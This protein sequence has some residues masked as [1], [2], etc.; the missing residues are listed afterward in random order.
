MCGIRPEERVGG[1][2]MCVKLS[3]SEMDE[4]MSQKRLRWF[5]HVARSI[6]WINQCHEIE[7]EGP[8]R[9]GR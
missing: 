3:I 9:R 1:A 7:V 4:K 5:G 8:S 6:D 2:M